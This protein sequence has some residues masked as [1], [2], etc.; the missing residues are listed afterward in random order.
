MS[1][2]IRMRRAIAA[3]MADPKKVIVQATITPG[4]VVVTTTQ[5][6]GG[7]GFGPNKGFAPGVGGNGQGQGITTISVVP[8]SGGNAGVKKTS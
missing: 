5:G 2:A 8:G 7:G 1:L 6:A 4:Y 3:F